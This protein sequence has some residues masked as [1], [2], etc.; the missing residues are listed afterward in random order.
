MQLGL[1]VAA[2]LLDPGQAGTGRHRRRRQEALVEV[3]PHRLQDLPLDEVRLIPSRIPPHRD[4]PH[5]S[6]EQRLQMLNAA[7]QGAAGLIKTREAP[8]SPV[9]WWTTV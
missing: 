7:V 4:A 1:A 8:C 3:A 9:A 6:A 5:A 2:A